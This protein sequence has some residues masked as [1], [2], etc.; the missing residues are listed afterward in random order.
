MGCACGE[1]AVFAPVVGGV[2][3]AGFVC[4]DPDPCGCPVSANVN[5][6]RMT[7]AVIVIAAAG[8]LRTN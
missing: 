3:I 4:A 5:T 7:V 6:S 8:H 1:G 2:A